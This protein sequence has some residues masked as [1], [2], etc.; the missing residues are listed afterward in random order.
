MAGHVRDYGIELLGS[1]E[2]DLT[3]CVDGLTA[4]GSQ[5]LYAYTIW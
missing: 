1:L 5:S 2:G 3:L 4:A